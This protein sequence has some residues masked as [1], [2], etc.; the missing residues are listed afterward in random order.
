M[1]AADL[2]ANFDTLAAAPYSAEFE[3]LLLPTLTDG[4]WRRVIPTQCEGCAKACNEHKV[5]DAVGFGPASESKSILGELID[6][7]NAVRKR[8]RKW[9][10]LIQQMHLASHGIYESATESIDFVPPSASRTFTVDSTGSG[11]VDLIYDAA[12]YDPRAL[13]FS[14]LVENPDYGNPGE[15]QY[16]TET[17]YQGLKPRTILQFNAPSL[18]RNFDGWI[19]KKIACSETIA[20]TETFRVYLEGYDGTEALTKNPSDSEDDITATIKMYPPNSD[21]PWESIRDC[22][23]FWG[24][25]KSTV[26]T[27]TGGALQTLEASARIKSPSAAE[28]FIVTDKNGNTLNWANRVVI[29]QT[30]GGWSTSI[31]VPDITSLQPVTVTYWVESTADDAINCGQSRCK[32]SIHDETGSWGDTDGDGTAFCKLRQEVF[33][34]PSGSTYFNAYRAEC[35][36]INCPF[37]TED[38]GPTDPLAAIEQVITSHPYK[39]TIIDT[40][41]VITTTLERWG[42]PSL[43][44]LTSALRRPPEGLQDKQRFNTSAGGWER[45]RV[46]GGALYSDQGLDWLDC[47]DDRQVP[48]L[49]SLSTFP[50]FGPGGG[51]IS[52]RLTELSDT[53]ASDTLDPHRI[54]RA[55]V[56]TRDV[57][58][59]PYEGTVTGD[60]GKRQRI[61]VYQWSEFLPVVGSGSEV[62][63]V[64]GTLYRGYWDANFQECSE[65][66]ETYTVKIV[67]GDGQW[68]RYGGAVLT[69]T[70][71]YAETAGAYVRLHLAH[72]EISATSPVDSGGSMV[73]STTSWMQGGTNVA[74]PMFARVWNYDCA[75]TIQGPGQ[76]Y[77]RRGHI[78]SFLDDDFTGT[79]LQGRSMWI[80]YAKACGSSYYGSWKPDGEGAG[81]TEEEY[82]ESNIEIHSEGLPFGHDTWAKYY[83]VIDVY[84]PYYLINNYG[85]ANMIGKTINIRSDGRLIDD[86]AAVYQTYHNSPTEDQQ[87]TGAKIHGASGEI[88]LESISDD[89]NTCIV[90]TGYH[91]DRRVMPY[92]EELESIDTTLARM[93]GE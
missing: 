2:S 33:T 45:S 15:P 74:L 50:S 6:G 7:G 73:E 23:P 29:T 14:Y 8:V 81:Q 66:S 32:W 72:K 57:D 1:T 87:I 16:I 11:Y 83:D 35:Y 22:Y 12:S 84:D 91:A 21:E 64:G 36:Q 30:G 37:W 5:F 18:L 52:G 59:N 24:K 78:V 10:S 88:F 53:P 76:D 77:A 54:D 75:Q 55:Q 34:D 20:D 51:N 86:G 63:R 93:I 68:E 42:V 49:T 25:R 82:Y 85:T 71:A 4:E 65:G 90:V 26:L 28:W 70:V 56:L 79:I 92:A 17:Q 58:L 69:S 48:L 62:N 3:N 44:S 67:L 43:Y 39:T 60:L 80:S 27:G 40:E 13:E 89:P 41:G 9:R 61:G 47:N 46:N 31:D 19:V 38:D